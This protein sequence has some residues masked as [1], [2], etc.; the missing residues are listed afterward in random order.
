MRDIH[1]QSQELLASFQS[2]CESAVRAS[3]PVEKPTQADIAREFLSQ[4]T[5]QK[6]ILWE[7][8]YPIRYQ[9]RMLGDI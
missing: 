3:T 8:I 7:S 4:L 6:R 2:Y 9:L 1:E 5:P